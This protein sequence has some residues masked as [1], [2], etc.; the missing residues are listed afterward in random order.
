VNEF[1]VLR[2]RIDGRVE[3]VRHERKRG[4]DASIT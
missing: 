2:L 1:A 3:G 4:R